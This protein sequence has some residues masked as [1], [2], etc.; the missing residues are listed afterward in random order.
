[1]IGAAILPRT[2]KK[3]TKNA[4]LNLS[5]CCGAI[6]R[7]REKL[8]YG[9]TTTVPQVHNSPKDI[10]ERLLPVW[11][12]VRTILFVP[13]R[14]RTT[15]TNFDN[16]CQ[17]Y[18][19]ICGKIYIGAHLRSRPETTAVDFFQINQLSSGAHKLFRRFLHFSQFLTAISRKWWR[20]LATEM[21][22]I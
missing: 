8:Q 15:Y 1:M 18:I 16:F 5:L 19:A 21:W 10:L 11:L 2:G 9:W 20:H 17:R 13:S 12:L 22:T 4:V 6:W 7:R 14:F 3:M